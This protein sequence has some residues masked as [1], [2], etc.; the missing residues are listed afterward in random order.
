MAIKVYVVAEPSVIGFIEEGD[1][2]GF[3]EMLSVDDTLIFHDP[4]IFDTEKEVVAFTSGIA[5]GLDERAPAERAILRSDIEEDL[6]FIEAIE[7]Y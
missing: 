6:P 2:E 3:K 7:N 1:L 4:E 5:Y